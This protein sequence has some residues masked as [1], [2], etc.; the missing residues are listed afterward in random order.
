MHKLFIVSFK[1]GILKSKWGLLGVFLGQF[2]G[3][4]GGFVSVISFGA[5][6]QRQKQRPYLG[7]IKPGGAVVEQPWGWC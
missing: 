2:F 3:V 6:K 4:F 7:L 5:R 1:L